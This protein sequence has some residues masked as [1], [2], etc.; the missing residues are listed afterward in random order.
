MPTI[1]EKKIAEICDCQSSEIVK[2]IKY[3][4]SLCN[5]VTQAARDGA[6]YT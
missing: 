2:V 3:N 6:N 4:I 5:W 1:I